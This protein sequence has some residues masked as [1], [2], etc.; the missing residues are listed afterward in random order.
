MVK[1]KMQTNS[2]ITMRSISELLYIRT[3]RR[4]GDKN[5]ILGMPVENPHNCYNTTTGENCF[6]RNDGVEKADW[7]VSLYSKTDCS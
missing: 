5:P 6:V 7:P 4:H 2:K 3:G 1:K